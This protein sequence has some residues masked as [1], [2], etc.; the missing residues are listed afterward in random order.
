MEGTQKVGFLL[1]V[2]FFAGSVVLM[3]AHEIRTKTM[4]RGEGS[5]ASARQL[6]KELRGE[7]VVNKKQE[8]VDP[9]SLPQRRPGEYLQERDRQKLNSLLKQVLPATNE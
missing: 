9:S 5:T 6:I 2:L 4:K 1:L 7:S 8:Y 3:A